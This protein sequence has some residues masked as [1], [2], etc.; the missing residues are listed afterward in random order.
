M[1]GSHKRAYWPAV[2]L[3]ALSVLAVPA[4][5]VARQAI[6]PYAMLVVKAD[7]E[8]RLYPP[9]TDID[10]DIS[11]QRSYELQRQIVAAKLA[12]RDAIA[13]YKAGLMTPASQKLRQANGPIFGVLLRSGAVAR[14][15]TLA[16]KDYRTMVL[17]CEIGFVFSKRISK[18][19]ADV[20]TLKRAI[21]AVRPTIEV[22]DVAYARTPYSVRD[23]IASNVSAARYIYGRSMPLAK[24][25]DLNRIDPVLFHGDRQIAAGHATDALGD[26]WRA[27]LAIVNLAVGQGYVIEPRQTIITG[28]LALKIAPEAGDYRADF[29]PLGELR[30]TVAP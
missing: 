3:A 7:K 1:S 16:L 14:P 26:Q 11:E 17:E 30:F 25:G 5:V 8:H 24:A 4:A 27:L 22:P 28:A 12:H 2:G 13:G 20:A 10:P 23:M 18:P 9:V 19:V 21:G 6:D 29:G 15:A